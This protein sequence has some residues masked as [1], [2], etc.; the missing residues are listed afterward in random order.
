MSHETVD[1]PPDV[2][3][4]IRS[5]TP[6][7]DAGQEASTPHPPTKSTLNPEATPFATVPP[8][9][10]FCSD[11]MQTVF[12]QT[13]RAVI[14]HPSKPHDSLEVRLVLDGSQKSYIS[15][16]ARDLLKLEPAG[17]QHRNLRLQQGNHKGMSYCR[18][19]PRGYPSMSPSLYAMPIICEPLVGQ[20]ISMCVR[21]HPHLL[22][23]ELADSPDTASNTPIDMLIGSDYYWQLVTGSICRGTSGPVAVHTKLGW[24]LSSPSSLDEHDQCSM[25]LSIAQSVTHVLHSETHSVEHCTLDDQLQSFWELE[26]LGIQDEERTL[27]DDFASSVKFENGRYKVTLPWRE[28]HNPLPD[29]HQ[30]SANRLQGLL[31]RLRQ[32]PAILEEYDHIIQDQ[33]KEGIIESIQPDEAPPGT[34]HY[35][36]HHAVIRRDKA[37]TKVRVVYDASARSANSPSLNDCLLKGPKFNQLIF[38]L[39]VRFRSYKVALTADLEKAFLMVSVKETDRDVL[40]FLW[41][42]DIKQEPPKFEAYRF[43][44][45][46]FGVSSSPFLLNATIRFHLEKYLKTNEDLVCRLLCSTYVDDIIAGGKTEEE[47]CLLYTSPSPRDATLSRM[48]SSA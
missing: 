34:V 39:L 11:N 37:T 30:L 26:A 4:V 35:L 17:E 2:K 27:F 42:K 16:R 20:S 47:A 40:R 46:V 38:D 31:R 8:T 19:C 22:G 44:R 24:V 33:L 28:F 32:E 9:T 6:I 43:T 13:V 25:N 29:N 3:G 21:Q 23:L 15:E 12:L 1:H 5:T 48:P 41:V 18:M 7:C 45:V 14:H 10:A 36:P